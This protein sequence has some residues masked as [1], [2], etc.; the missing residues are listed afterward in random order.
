MRL[1]HSRDLYDLVAMAKH[2]TGKSALQDRTLLHR[3][4]AFKERYF[5]NSWSNFGTARPGS[6]RIVPPGHRM[7][8]LRADYRQMRPMFLE[9]PPAFEELIEALGK[10]E[11]LI[12]RP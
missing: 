10:I 1:R 9:E 6:F 11:E 12:N 8:A 4:V 5:R 3:V 7:A 2:E